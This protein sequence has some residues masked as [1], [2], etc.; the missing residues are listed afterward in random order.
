MQT[1]TNTELKAKKAKLFDKLREDN[2][3]KNVSDTD[4]KIMVDTLY[5]LEIKHE[6]L[7]VVNHGK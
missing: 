2:E 4:L 3:L 7:K 5:K 1:I 6:M